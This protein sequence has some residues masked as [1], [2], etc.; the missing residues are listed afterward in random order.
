MLEWQ[1]FDFVAGTI[2]IQPTK[3]YSLKTDDSSAVLPL[4]AEILAL[5]RAWR[6]KASGSF[7]IESERA[8]QLVDHQ[9]YRCEK[10][11]DA[12][13]K[14][15][16]QKGVQG[17]SP[18]HA[19]RKMF[20]SAMCDRHGIHAASSALRHSNLKTTAEHYVD[21]RV[22][23][24]AGFGAELSGAAVTPF[25]LPVDAAAGSLSVHR[26]LARSQSDNQG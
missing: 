25:P 9:W 7:V 22:R 17:H 23:V 24:T 11:F 20:G 19:L 18:F 10:T 2:R 6:A 3:W 21:R 15:L 13:L 26:I 8:P 4:E 16:R 12:L 14:W 5:F 1:S